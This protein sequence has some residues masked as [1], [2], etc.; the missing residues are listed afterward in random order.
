MAGHSEGTPTKKTPRGRKSS[1]SLTSYREGRV[2]EQKGDKYGE[3]KGRKASSR[4]Y[5]N[6]PR[7]QFEDEEDKH[8]FSAKMPRKDNRAGYDDPDNYRFNERKREEKPAHRKPPA[9]QQE[10]DYELVKPQVQKQR[11]NQA[12][13]KE[14][15][16]EYV[17]KSEIGKEK[18]KEVGTVN[19][20]F[21]PDRS[22]KE[23]RGQEAEPELQQLRV[24]GEEDLPRQPCNWKH[25]VGAEA[26]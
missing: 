26:R 18:P 2:N 21:K 17:K 24:F 5:D 20:G 9:K 13:P 1:I 7:Y 3:H 19:E 22:A 6:I 23:Q 25:R 8:K 15:D 12:K 14:A 11:E 16:F 4:E 10:Y